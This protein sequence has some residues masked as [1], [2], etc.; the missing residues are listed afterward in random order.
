MGISLC[1]IIKDEEKS[2]EGFLAHHRK[3]ADEI[4]VV[5]TGS[6]DNSA[7]IAKRFTARVFHFKWADDFS[8]AR[9]FSILQATEQWIVWLD[10]DERICRNDFDRIRMLARD[11]SCL[12]YSFIQKTFTN[13]SCVARFTRGDK[14]GFRGYYIRRICK[15]FQN[16][17]GIRFQYPV[18]ESVKGHIDELGG[19]IKRT[20]VVIEHYPELKP[21]ESLIEKHKMY[22]KLL[23][24]KETDF[25]GSNAAKEIGTENDFLGY[26]SESQGL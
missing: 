5:D 23:K 13:A 18:H 1:I 22:I 12:G 15:M 10:P 3:L 4:I 19:K 14:N 17:A 2:L 8:L 9:N 26:Y 11:T 16:S 7:A 6:K 21:I 20:G 25:P 24:R